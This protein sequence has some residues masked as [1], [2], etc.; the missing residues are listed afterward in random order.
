M[1]ILNF[2]EID[3]NSKI[4]KEIVSFMNSNPMEELPNIDDDDFEV[5][6]YSNAGELLK[7]YFTDVAFERSPIEE[8]IKE[9]INVNYDINELV[10]FCFNDY[11]FRTKENEFLEI[12]V[13]Q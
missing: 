5:I 3:V 7:D 8:M 6:H 2:R 1:R 4:K 9:M 12:V 10:K 13:E 11:M